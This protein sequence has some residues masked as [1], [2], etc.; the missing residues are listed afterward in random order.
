MS[1]Q[2]IVACTECGRLFWVVMLELVMQAFCCPPYVVPYYTSTAACTQLG[3]S[4]LSYFLLGLG[5][6]L[7][8]LWIAGVAIECLGEGG[9]PSVLHIACPSHG[10]EAY[11]YGPVPFCSRVWSALCGSV[12]TSLRQ[13]G[14][15]WTLCAKCWQMYVCFVWS[16]VECLKPA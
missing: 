13:V 2:Q 3:G 14:S 7:A 9:L 10:H 4:R 12:A 15:L 16:R 6:G 1:L 8:P 11:Q 5:Q